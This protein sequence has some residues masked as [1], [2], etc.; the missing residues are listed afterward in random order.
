MEKY[1]TST[2]FVPSWIKKAPVAAAA[3]PA[4]TAAAVAASRPQQ[5]APTTTQLQGGA[6]EYK[7]R[8]TTTNTASNRSTKLE[9]QSSPAPFIPK[10]HVALPTNNAPPKASPQ[11]TFAGV[12]TMVTPNSTPKQ[13]H[14]DASSASGTPL[15]APKTP[16]LAANRALEGVD[17]EEVRKVALT[18]TMKAT[19]AS[20]VPTGRSMKASMAL[21]PISLAPQDDDANMQLTDNWTLYFLPSPPGKDEP[22]DPALVFGIDS[23]AAYWKT[24]NNLPEAEE[25]PAR[26]SMYLFRDDIVPKWEDPQNKDGGLYRVAVSSRHANDVWLRTTARTIGESWKR[27][28]RDNVNGIVLKVKEKGMYIEI[29][30]K[31]MIKT[32]DGK[33]DFRNEWHSAFSNIVE[34]A[35]IDYY[36][37]QELQSFIQQAAEN[38]K[39]KAKRKY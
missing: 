28:Y 26:S 34:I 4:P 27:L 17:L 24:M 39:K 11:M 13:R 9:P 22:F 10:T 32:A 21:S 36:T 3:P 7:P 38:P 37:H 1:A 2:E 18:S 25:L 16:V 19:A 6:A 33:D 12:V 31:R 35:A 23:V 5:V 14:V 8:F 15:M 30:V 20:F 29:W